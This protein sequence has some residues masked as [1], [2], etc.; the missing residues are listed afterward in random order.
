MDIQK[1]PLHSI[2]AEA[3]LDR[4]EEEASELIHAIVKRRRF[5]IGSIHPRTG[6]TAEERIISEAN[7]INI[8]LE[9]YFFR[10][11]EGGSLDPLPETARRLSAED[12]GAH[13]G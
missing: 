13:V 6:E 8:V 10:L 4:L 9:E 5:G 2:S 7:D 1:Y 3:L 12:W 11:G